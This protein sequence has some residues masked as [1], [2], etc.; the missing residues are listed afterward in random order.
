MHPNFEKNIIIGSSI[1]ECTRY[2]RQE[3]EEEAKM[4]E[5]GERRAFKVSK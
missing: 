5:V 2:T 4:E 1:A 3:E